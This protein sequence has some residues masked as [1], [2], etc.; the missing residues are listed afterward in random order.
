[1]V[2][3]QDRKEK[4]M[5]LRKLTSVVLAGLFAGALLV[6]TLPAT[7]D[8]RDGDKHEW[9]ENKGKKYGHYKKRHVKR[10]RWN[11]RPYHG[12]YEHRRNARY[13]RRHYGQRNRA[14]I[15]Q[16]FKDVRNARKEVHQSRT[17]LRKD[18]AEL[19]R[20]RAELRRDIRN[21]ASKAEIRQGR[22]EI[23][24]DLKEIRE[25][26]AE[27]REDQAKLDAARRELKSDLRRR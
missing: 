1:L 11:D 19:R 6:P 3:E 16:D 8:A 14:E 15:R 17:E 2:D 20:D 9:H 21:G 12:R 26:R 4:E 23:R 10:S 25:S 27:L 7:A 5:E 13:D 18:Y 22:Q 24:N